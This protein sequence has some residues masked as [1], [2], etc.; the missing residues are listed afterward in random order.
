LDY[1]RC[2]LELFF[3]YIETGML[4][5]F[6]ELNEL[7]DVLAAEISISFL[8]DICGDLGQMFIFCTNGSLHL[9]VLQPFEGLVLNEL[10][11]VLDFFEEGFESY[12]EIVP[13]PLALPHKVFVLLGESFSLEN[14]VSVVSVVLLKLFLVFFFT[15]FIASMRSSYKH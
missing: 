3:I 5:S 13:G 14:A 15:V 7:V 9:F 6:P 8:H 4:L 11:F 12:G 1:V 2:K 10:D